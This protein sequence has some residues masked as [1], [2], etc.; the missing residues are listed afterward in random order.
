MPSFETSNAPVTLAPPESTRRLNLRKTS[1]DD[2][3]RLYE[4]RAGTAK[5]LIEASKRK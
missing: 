3:R 1:V 4:E 2:L 5:S